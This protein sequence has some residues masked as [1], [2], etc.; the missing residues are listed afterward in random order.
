[1]QEQQRHHSSVEAQ[2]I[3]LF[4]PLED[5]EVP[6][7][8]SDALQRCFGAGGLI[9]RSEGLSLVVSSSIG[10]GA[11]EER[12]TVY[13]MYDLRPNE[14]YIVPIENNDETDPHNQ[15]LGRD[16]SQYL[17]VCRRQ[18]REMSALF[19][20]APTPSTTQT[21]REEEEEVDDDSFI[22]VVMSR[23]E[24]NEREPAAA[25]AAV[26]GAEAPEEAQRPLLVQFEVQS[27]EGEEFLEAY[28]V[29]A[30]LHESG[31]PQEAAEAF[32]A[33]VPGRLVLTNYR[34][35]FVPK[36]RFVVPRITIERGATPVTT[37]QF[38]LAQVI[39]DYDVGETPQTPEAASDEQ[40]PFVQPEA[41]KAA[42]ATM[43]KRVFTPQHTSSPATAEAAA[44]AHKNCK[45]LP[46][47]PDVIAKVVT[48]APQQQQ[49]QQTQQQYQH[50]LAEQ[51]DSR[52][53]PLWKQPIWFPLWL[54][55][56]VSTPQPGT[57][58]RLGQFFFG[59]LAT[60]SQSTTLE[61]SVSPYYPS[62]LF[63]SLRFVFKRAREC[64]RA[65]TI[66]KQAAA[67]AHFEQTF[68]RHYHCSEQDT[69]PHRCRACASQAAIYPMQ[70][71]FER[72]G[73]DLTSGYGRWRL[74]RANKN[75]S[76][77]ESYPRSF[78][79]PA[80][81]SDQL[82]SASAEFRAKRRL[83]ILT[84][85]SAEGASI[86]RGAQPMSGMTFARSAQDEEYV[87]LIRQTNDAARPLHILDCRPYMNSIANRA[88]QGGSEG[89]TYAHCT[90]SYL[91]IQNIHAVR[92]SFLKMRSTFGSCRFAGVRPSAVLLGVAASA[93][94]DHIAA[95]LQGTAQVVRLVGHRHESVFVHCSDSW[96]RT[97]QLCALA[98]LCLDPYYRTMHG[99]ARLIE[100]DWLKVGHRFADR[101]R[102]DSLQLGERAPRCDDA[103]PIF[104][105]FIE[106]V[107]QLTQQYPFAFEFGETFLI[108]LYEEAMI[109]R[110]GTFLYNSDCERERYKVPQH[111]QSLW[112]Y[113]LSFPDKYRNPLYDSRRFASPQ[114]L[115]PSPPSPRRDA[116]VSPSPLQS[117]VGGEPLKVAT[118]SAVSQST[119]LG[120]DVFNQAPREPPQPHR[121]RVKADIRVRDCD[122]HCMGSTY[123]SP[124]HGTIAESSF[125]H[126]GDDSDSDSDR[127]GSTGDSSTGGS[128][129][130]DRSNEHDDPS[131]GGDSGSGGGSED[132][133]GADEEMAEVAAAHHKAVTKAAASESA[134]IMPH[135]QPHNLHIWYGFFQ[136]YSQ[137]VTSMVP[138]TDLVNGDAFVLTL[139]RHI[140]AMQ[141]EICKLRKKLHSA[142]H[143][144]QQQKP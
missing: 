67:P 4:Y 85:V 126:P 37:S 120:A 21:E 42:A 112:L 117:A 113:L 15:L 13:S 118:T 56:S 5:P 1:M 91:D 140:T 46:L 43:A 16:S 141:A 106:C 70:E 107:W 14:V 68:A 130:L 77:C 12:H 41:I 32:A 35:L 6:F 18:G 99:F 79:V 66:I 39:D 65:A 88:T 83:P 125:I 73:L 17:L 92:D 135:Y 61:V 124:M 54:V 38:A 69:G 103:S 2:V 30:S 76:L 31:V 128:G 89:A 33:V 96:D 25:A 97:S 139:S 53:S 20:H 49:Q 122:V 93:W 111:S 47:A 19:G 121:V 110:F 105:Q 131:D 137:G 26:E 9:C 72:Q 44:E 59:L 109:G 127:E 71:E 123:L 45:S 28:D 23:E 7:V 81:A 119:L 34:L 27:L 87:E 133:D 57:A 142:R 75:Y 116:R 48:P 80:S 50:Q 144:Q 78:V 10:N 8:V 132:D 95:V 52:E 22:G 64:E 55:S 62:P 101:M 3:M 63:A 104:L 98:Q 129:G 74:T 84:W 138:A 60:D 136:R 90:V 108:D 51:K 82:V 134:I 29:D 100:K 114:A 115:A 94:Y 86:T 11:R 143:Q 36:K 102:A 40:L 24:R 58:A